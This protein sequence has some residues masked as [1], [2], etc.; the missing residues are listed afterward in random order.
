MSV[1]VSMEKSSSSTEVSTDSTDESTKD[2]TLK[3][4]V[5]AII[6]SHVRRKLEL[7]GRCNQESL[8]KGGGGKQKNPFKTIDG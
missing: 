1:V 3:L 8:K 7:S 5:V 6:C 2:S 4:A